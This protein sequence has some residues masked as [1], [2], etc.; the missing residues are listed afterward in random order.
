M[1]DAMM[2]TSATRMVD[3]PMPVVQLAVR[4]PATHAAGSPVPIKLVVENVARLP[5]KMSW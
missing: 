2:L 5:A 4:A 1:R 3:G